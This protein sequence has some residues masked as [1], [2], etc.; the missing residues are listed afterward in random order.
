[1]DLE[2]G[3]IP[4]LEEKYYLKEGQKKEKNF[5]FSS[6]IINKRSFLLYVAC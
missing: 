6:C 1:M 2:K 4:K 5:Q 3:R